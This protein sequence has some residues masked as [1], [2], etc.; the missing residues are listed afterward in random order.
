MAYYLVSYN[1]SVYGNAD[2][3]RDYFAMSESELITASLVGKVKA[4]VILGT[5]FFLLS[6]DEVKTVMERYHDLSIQQLDIALRSLKQAEEHNKVVLLPKE[7]STVP[8][9]GTKFVRFQDIPMANK[10]NHR[11]LI[12]HIKLCGCL[13]AAIDRVLVDNPKES[14]VLTIKE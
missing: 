7:T 10:Y 4:Q 8:L 2:L 3:V 11:M 9:S 5:P 12:P 6:N 1:K 14:Y 13:F